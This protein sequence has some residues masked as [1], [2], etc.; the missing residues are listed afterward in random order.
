MPS[1]EL[2]SAGVW[3]KRLR[4][5]LVLQHFKNYRDSLGKEK[6]RIYYCPYSASCRRLMWKKEQL[7]FHAVQQHPTESGVTSKE[8][9]QHCDEPW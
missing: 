1:V 6:R 5:P 9:C 2:R 8:I 3:V 4:R 7:N